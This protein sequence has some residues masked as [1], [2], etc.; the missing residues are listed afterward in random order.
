MTFFH[1][2]NCSL[3]T[4]VPFFIVYKSTVLA[5]QSLM[6]T[7]VRGAFGFIATQLCSMILVATFIPN[8]DSDAFDMKKELASLVVNMG[9]IVGIYLALT[10]VKG[11]N[12]NDQKV[13]GIGLGWSFGEAILSKFLP[14]WIGARGLE[15]SWEHTMSGVEA[16]SAMLLTIVLTA[17]VWSSNR[18]D[19][20]GSS[21]SQISGLMIAVLILPR[22]VSYARLVLGWSSFGATGCNIVGSVVLA[23]L[24]K[25]V[26]TSC[27]LIKQQ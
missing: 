18:K 12:G 17:L 23:L 14:L 7:C 6:S 15:F 25:P 16:N 20:D 8:F 10:M 21:M 19:I 5:E 11:N 2:I 26:Y 24:T 13:L 22:L 9:D 1:F 4:Y 3:L 27:K